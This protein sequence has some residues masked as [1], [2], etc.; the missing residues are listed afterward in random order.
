[1]PAPDGTYQISFIPMSGTA[2]AT[3]TAEAGGEQQESTTTSDGA[4]R[5]SMPVRKKKV[6]PEPVVSCRRRR[7]M[8]GG[9]END[10]LNTK[11][12]TSGNVGEK[13]KK[14]ALFHS[15]R[16]TG[17]AKVFKAETEEETRNVNCGI[18]MIAPGSQAARKPGTNNEDSITKPI[19]AS[20]ADLI[21]LDESRR[22][23]KRH[24]ASEMEAERRASRVRTENPIAVGDRRSARNAKWRPMW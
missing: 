10:G 12:E 2:G 7:N 5:N 6:E 13:R 4:M 20:A 22:R 18:G 15:R 17:Q 14:V 9:G 21:K 1:V 8:Q 19:G 3:A 24:I 16:P 23:E 11:Q